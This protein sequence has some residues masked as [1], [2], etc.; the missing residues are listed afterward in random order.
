MRSKNKNSNT[1][2]SKA[3]AKN[4]LKFKNSEPKFRN[5]GGAKVRGSD[6]KMDFVS[7]NVL[8][9]KSEDSRIRY[10]LDVVKDGT[11]L[12]T[13]GVLNPGEELDLV[14]ETMRRVDDGF[15]GIEVCSLR[16]ET[17]GYQRLFEQ[18]S[19][20]TNRVEKVLSKIIGREPPKA[21]LKF[22]MTLIGPSKI[23]KQI[24]KNPN[25]FS[26]FAGK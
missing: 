21:D 1:K 12:V 10:I 19:E 22:G 4:K 23:I 8:N 15:P 25:S 5:I 18:V 9:R 3:N 11:I 2:N 26:V 6:L 13:D 7:S 20:Q 24:K 17:D 14:R 16:R